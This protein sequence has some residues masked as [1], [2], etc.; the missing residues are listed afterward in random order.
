MFKEKL[1]LRGNGLAPGKP[2]L[3]LVEEMIASF[4]ESRARWLAF[5]KRISA[6]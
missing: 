2:F 3:K 6:S 5:G 1:P 4:I